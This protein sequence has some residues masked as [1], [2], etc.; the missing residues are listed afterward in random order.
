MREELTRSQALRRHR[1]MWRRLAKSGESYG[2]KRSALRPGDGRVINE[3]YLCEFALGGSGIECVSLCPIDWGVPR[4]PFMCERD[5]RSFYRKW[6]AAHSILRRKF[7]AAQI[8]E[9]PR[10]RGGK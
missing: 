9:L 6:K 1:A 8:A 3:C 5:R 7:F 4:I 2:N 10:Y